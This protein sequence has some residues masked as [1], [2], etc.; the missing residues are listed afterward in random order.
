MHFAN[1]LGLCH[2]YNTGTIKK[3]IKMLYILRIGL[4]FDNSGRPTTIHHGHISKSDG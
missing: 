4:F 3:V 1:D 2:I